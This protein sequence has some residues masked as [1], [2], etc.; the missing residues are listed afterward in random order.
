MRL[1]IKTRQVAGVTLIVGTAVI[2]LSGF[3]LSS[4]VRIRLEESQARGELLANATFH[5]ARE[6]VASSRDPRSALGD[7][8]GLRS[9]LE[10]SAYSR[11][12]TYAAIV[13]VSG[14]AI[15]H[16][17]ERS[18][19][20]TL[21]PRGQL[22][23]LLDEGALSQWRAIYA[24]DGRTLE[25]GQPLLL[26]GVEFGSIR[27]GISTLLMRSD[28][29]AALRPALATA[30]VALMVASLAAML[31]ARR[32]LRPIHLIRSGLTSLQ[33]GDF[34]VQLNLAQQDEFGELGDFFNSVSARLSADRSELAGRKARLL[35]A[36][37]RLS[38]GVA[39]EIKNPLNAM[40]IHLE[41]LRHQLS[42]PENPGGA[43]E[44][45]LAAANE[46]ASVIAV[47]IRRLD[48]V[49]QGFLKL[50]RPGE[51]VLEPIAVAALFE[52]VRPVVEAEARK[53]GVQVDISC[54]P[55]LPDIRGDAGMLRQTFLNLA[56]NACQAM[57]NGG[58]LR[59]SAAAA[60]GRRVEIVFEDTGLGIAPEHLER[61]FDLYFTTRAEGSGI[62]L[63]MVHRIVQLHDGDI[64]VQSTPGQ[65]TTFRLLLAQA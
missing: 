22:G 5:R 61:I 20:A 58:T 12:V 39:H 10:A 56:L 33:E 19:G 49:V 3:Y 18:V 24:A 4:L 23:D 34:G 45:D 28:L 65:G 16:S 52:E 53:N 29:N 6:V 26:G 27:I 9:I 47:Q 43:G 60:P 51:V 37:G 32:F 57:P 50:T 55:A 35:A 7:D 2:V 64:E 46:H 41:L 25:V 14:V 40:M 1:S 36:F 11:N 8:A 30:I 44:I 13:D 21:E 62:G 17:D 15:A 59:M 31:L 38:T 63:S 54:P 48:E 42:P